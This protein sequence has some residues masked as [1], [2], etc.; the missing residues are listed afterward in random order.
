MMVDES[1]GINGEKV[2]LTI[3]ENDRNFLKEH[4]VPVPAALAMGVQAIR[5]LFSKPGIASLPLDE[6]SLKADL[7][8]VKE[9][10]EENRVVLKRLGEA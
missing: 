3:T 10:L 2:T 9:I 7:P 1:T 4:G 6:V 5:E 8:M